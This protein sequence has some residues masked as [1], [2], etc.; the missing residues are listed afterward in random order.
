MVDNTTNL[1]LV[2]SLKGKR[3]FIVEDNLENRVIFQMVF[4]KYGAAVDFERWGHA[5]LFRLQNMSNVDLIILDLML[6]QGISGFDVYDSIRGLPQYLAVPIVAVSAMDPNVAIP[7]TQ[8][9]GFNGFIAKPI[10]SHLFPRQIASIL[11]GQS[12]WYAGERT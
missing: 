7:K 5:T 3:V 12:V 2:E 1:H 8:A 6:A 10:D 9:R 11:E 4:V